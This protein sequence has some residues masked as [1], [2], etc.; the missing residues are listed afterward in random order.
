MIY[1]V[2]NGQSLTIKFFQFLLA[3]RIEVVGDRLCPLRQNLFAASVPWALWAYG[4][5]AANESPKDE[6][7]NP[8]SFKQIH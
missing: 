3:F 7:S 5:P 6:Q 8:F 4:F 2:T 1:K